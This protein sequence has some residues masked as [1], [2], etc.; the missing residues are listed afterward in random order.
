MRTL[1]EHKG[2]AGEV[3]SSGA[4]V[5]EGLGASPEPVSSGGTVVFHYAGPE[6][7]H[8]WTVNGA[9]VALDV[10]PSAVAVEEGDDTLFESAVSV[11]VALPAGSVVTATCNGQ[12]LSVQVI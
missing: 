5:D 12:M 11:P 4:V 1:F 3:L 9:G 6:A 2:V 7:V 8:T 10:P